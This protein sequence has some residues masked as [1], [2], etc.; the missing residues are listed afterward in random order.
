MQKQTK[1]SLNF[2]AVINEKIRGENHHGTFGFE[3]RGSAVVKAL[4]YKPEGRML[5]I[6]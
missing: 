2:I 5:Q 6:R 4:R 3:A 1:E